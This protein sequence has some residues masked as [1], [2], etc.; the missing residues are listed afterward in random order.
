MKTRSEPFSR[1][2][3]V[4]VMG[5]SVLAYRAYAVPATGP[6]DA[7]AASQTAPAP[8][9]GDAAEML[10]PVKAE[11]PN[12]FVVRDLGIEVRK[13]DSWV[14][15]NIDESRVSRF[16]L[17]AK[18]ASMDAA[19]AISVDSIVICQMNKHSVDK[20]PEGPNPA[21]SISLQNVV[22][23][24]QVTDAKELAKYGTSALG[25]LFREI[26]WLEFLE[27]VNVGGQ[28]GYKNRFRASIDPKIWGG[29]LIVEQHFLLQG[30]IAVC[31]TYQDGEESWKSTQAEFD[32]IKSALVIPA[33]AA[34][35][36]Q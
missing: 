5:V 18:S 15:V 16:D 4:L 19:K 17:I 32:Q 8:D 25:V 9:A 7:G 36:L 10:E 31:V 12:L 28:P 27:P 29:K 2:A 26:E 24:P 3:L 33:N 13:P 22:D 14:F 35:P 20:P 30:R 11:D 1:R 21:V 23:V 34:I 6:A